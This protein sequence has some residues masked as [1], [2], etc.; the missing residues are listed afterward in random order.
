M[1]KNIIIAILSVMLV[2]SMAGNV[3]LSLT[4]W[5]YIEASPLFSAGASSTTSLPNTT[6][7]PT[8]PASVLP[9]QTFALDFDVTN[10]G[11]A[12]QSLHSIDIWGDGPNGNCRLN[13]HSVTPAP[14]RIDQN[15]GYLTY[16]W[17]QTIPPGQTAR[18]SFQ[19]EALEQGVHDSYFDVCID[20]GMNWA[21]Q[22]IVI[23]VTPDAVEPAP[24]AADGTTPDAGSGTNASTGQAPPAPF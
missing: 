23:D 8:H 6:I 5:F 9:N 7:V 19:L 11:S 16:V 21:T 24:P 17:E 12:P 22:N 20:N 2:A 15:G 10:T 1:A 18:V 14:K 13:I 3:A 4:L